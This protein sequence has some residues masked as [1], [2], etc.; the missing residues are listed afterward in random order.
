[1]GL[2][3]VAVLQGGLAAIRGGG[4]VL[5]LGGALAGFGLPRG[6]RSEGG[7]GG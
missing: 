3:V 4:G 1:M 5:L 2:V 6:K 7:G